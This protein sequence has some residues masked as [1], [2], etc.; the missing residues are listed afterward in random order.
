MDAEKTAAIPI[1]RFARCPHCKYSFEGIGEQTVC[2]ECGKSPYPEILCEH[3]SYPVRGLE[4]QAMCPECGKPPR[5]RAAL[6]AV[7]RAGHHGVWTP[8]GFGLGLKHRFLGLGVDRVGRVLKWDEGRGFAVSDLSRRGVRRR[9]PHVCAFRLEPLDGGRSRLHV[10]AIGR[11]TATWMPRWLVRGWMW[12][13]LAGTRGRIEAEMRGFWLA[14]QR[15]G[16][17]GAKGL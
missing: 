7:P 6:Q 1:E 17:R 9:F 14:R 8:K 3:C 12:W 2:P 11:W 13:V 15:A 16:A 4:G 5:A 10:S